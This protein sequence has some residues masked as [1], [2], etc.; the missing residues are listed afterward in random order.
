MTINPIP[1]EQTTAITDALLAMFALFAVFY[2]RRFRSHDGWKFDLWSGVMLA[3]AAAAGLGAVAHGFVWSEKI[4]G[5][6]WSAIYLALGACVAGFVAAAVCELR[7]RS[8][9]IKTLATTLAT[10]LLVFV[11]AKLND[12]SFVP[13]VAFEGLA[14]MIALG[15]YGYLSFTIRLPGMIWMTFGVAL[16]LLAALFQALGWGS[17]ELIWSFDHNGTYHLIQMGG[18]AAIVAGLRSSVGN[19]R[20][21]S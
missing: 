19:P 10:A 16:T 13:F 4:N 11:A 17:F 14:M 1:T 9:A 6:I 12:D 3:L 15:I 18:L 8:A 5:A 20:F 2:L 21:R 7:G